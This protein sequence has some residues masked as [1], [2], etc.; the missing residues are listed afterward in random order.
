MKETK[1]NTDLL[2]KLLPAEYIISGFIKNMPDCD[3][4]VYLLE[5]INQSPFFM[6]KT[7]GS[8]FLRQISQSNGECDCYAGNEHNRYELDFKLFGSQKALQAKSIFS[9]QVEKLRDGYVYSVPKKKEGT[10]KATWIL[11]AL[12]GLSLFELE[13]VAHGEDLDRFDKDI[14]DDIRH[15]LKKLNVKKN[16]FLFLI[17]YF[18]FNNSCYVFNNELEDILHTL[19]TYLSGMLLYRKKYAE[20]HDTFFSFIFDKKLIISQFGENGIAL[21][22]V[23]DLEKSET[24]MKIDS[25]LDPM[26]SVMWIKGN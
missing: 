12:K 14:N 18:Y 20:G 1:A 4:E 24:F 5:C 11:K 16:L 19:N 22:D 17:E 3:S 8:H 25:T 23:V 7:R 26:N 10:I 21:V 2:I 15:V 13:Q 9:L 6:K